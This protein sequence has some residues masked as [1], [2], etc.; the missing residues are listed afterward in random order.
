MS[1]VYLMPRRAEDARIKK[2][3]DME[4]RARGALIPCS[5]RRLLRCVLGLLI[6]L[7]AACHELFFAALVAACSA[8]C[9]GNDIDHHLAVVLAARRAR[10][11]RQAKG[12][13]FAA[14]R[15]HGLQS[16]MTPALSCL[17]A[18]PP[19]S[20]YHRRLV[21]VFPGKKQKKAAGHASRHT[22]AYFHRSYF[23]RIVTMSV[24]LI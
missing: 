11:M 15:T 12:P 2:G 17:R 23:A 21:Y 4:K 8:G 19:H 16:M 20:D 24:F 1:L 3:V 9:A 18:V 7:L 13:A 10:S 14:G 22:D 5:K 6:N